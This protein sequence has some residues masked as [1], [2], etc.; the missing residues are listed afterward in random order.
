MEHEATSLV[1]VQKAI[2]SLLNKSARQNLST[3]AIHD[4]EKVVLITFTL[5]P[6]LDPAFLPHKTTLTE[7]PKLIWI[8]TAADPLYPFHC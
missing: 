1:H 8:S 2:R 7:E 6:D 3:D 5:D 4:I